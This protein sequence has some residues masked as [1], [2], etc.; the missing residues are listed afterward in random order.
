M[1]QIFNLWGNSSSLYYHRHLAWSC[2]GAYPSIWS[3]S[4]CLHLQLLA[5]LPSLLLLSFSTSPST[6]WLF[7]LANC[8]LGKDCRTLVTIFCSRYPTTASSCDLR[9]P[10]L[11]TTITIQTSVSR[12]ITSTILSKLLGLI[13]S[14]CNHLTPRRKQNLLLPRA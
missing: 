12:R 4:S 1:F 5:S 14:P 3:Y 7:L 8:H 9:V 6:L 10:W 13:S 2:A 11:P